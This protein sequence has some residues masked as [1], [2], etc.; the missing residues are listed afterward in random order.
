MRKVCKET[1]MWISVHGLLVRESRLGKLEH[2]LTAAHL[3]QCI[4]LEA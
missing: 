3:N 2:N 1:G 4:M